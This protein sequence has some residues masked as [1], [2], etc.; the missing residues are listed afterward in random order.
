MLLDFCF[1]TAA[2]AAT[3]Y[4]LKYQMHVVVVV[5]VV[6]HA[7]RTSGGHQCSGGGC[8]GGGI[9]ARLSSE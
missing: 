6:R 8:G 4:K 5:V 9:F 2:V 1:F 3:A 7:T